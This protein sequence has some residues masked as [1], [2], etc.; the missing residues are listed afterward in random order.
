MALLAR[1]EAVKSSCS[2][3]LAVP[4]PARYDSVA[5]RL[6]LRLPNARAFPRL[7]E[8][9]PRNPQPLRLRAPHPGRGPR[10][11]RRL[12]RRGPHRP[13]R[14]RHRRAL[15]RPRRR[16]G[17]RQPPER[18]T[19]AHHARRPLRPDRPHG[20]AHRRQRLPLRPAHRRLGHAN[21]ARPAP[22]RLDEER[23]RRRRR[24]APRPAP[25][26]QRGTQQGAAVH[27]RLGRYRRQGSQGRRGADRARRSGDGR[28]GLPRRCATAW[29]RR[30]RWTTKSASG[31]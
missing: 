2:I 12:R 11:G 21:P 28:A 23:P 16:A 1:G 22:D 13:P 17:R 26:D 18:R 25:A 10:L 5:R 27:R 31:R 6:Y 30:R 7:P 8:K 4:A 3:R 9:P 24:F 19:A 20:P 15:C 29:P 14:Q